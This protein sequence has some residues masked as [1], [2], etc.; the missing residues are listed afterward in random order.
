LALAAKHV[1]TFSGDP[2]GRV[3]LLGDVAFTL[4]TLCRIKLTLE[5]TEPCPEG[6]CPFWEHGG[7]VIEFGCGLERLPL[8]LD[9]PDL[10]RYLLDL[11]SALEATRDARERELARQAF[12]VLVPPDLSDH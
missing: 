9:R 8:E 2:D 1:G 6:A 12:A 11:R 10:A 4:K 7:A 5:E 3:A